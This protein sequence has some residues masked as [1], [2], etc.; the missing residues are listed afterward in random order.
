MS[1]ASPRWEPVLDGLELGSRDFAVVFLI[2]DEASQ[3]RIAE[4]VDGLIQ[5]HQSKITGSPRATTPNRNHHIAGCLSC[6]S[7]P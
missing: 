6:L 7:S 2:G 3:G 5:L 1:V 4:M